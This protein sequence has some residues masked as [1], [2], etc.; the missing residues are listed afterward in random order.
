M[1]ILKTA[2]L[3]WQARQY[4]RVGKIYVTSLIKRIVII[5]QVWLNVNVVNYYIENIHSEKE[6]IFEKKKY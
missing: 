5:E 3:Q 1:L 2:F 6:E 4:P